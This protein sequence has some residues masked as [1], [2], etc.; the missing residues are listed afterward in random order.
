LAGFEFLIQLRTQ[1][2]RWSRSDPFPNSSSQRKLGSQAA[3]R[4]RGR[5]QLSLGWREYVGR[6]EGAL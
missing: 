5:P 4:H 6:Q 1:I 2:R 3:S